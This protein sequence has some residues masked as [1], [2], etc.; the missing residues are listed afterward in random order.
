MRTIKTSADKAYKEPKDRNWALPN[1]VISQEEVQN[2]IQYA[3]K[4]PFHTVQESMQRFEQW[5]ESRKKR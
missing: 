2:A 4:G 1:Q 5:L 3:E